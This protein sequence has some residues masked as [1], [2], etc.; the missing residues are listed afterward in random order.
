MD[1]ATQATSSKLLE[2]SIAGASRVLFSI[3]GGPDLTLAEVDEAARIIEGCADEN[4]NIIY[5]QIIDEELSGEVHITVI[6]TGFTKSA[7]RQTSMDLSRRDLFAQTSRP[8]DT[9]AQAQPQSQLPLQYAVPQYAQTQYA[10]AQYAQAAAPA[11]T[12]TAAAQP[13]YYSS[14]LEDENYIPDFLRRNR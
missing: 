6:A 10:D 12:Q 11:Q 1:A 3:S 9:A 13:R 8:E 4:A 7:P 5:G 14:P 2:N